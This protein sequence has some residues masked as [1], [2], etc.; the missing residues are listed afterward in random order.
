MCHEETRR[1]EED[2]MPAPKPCPY[3][4]ADEV[5]HVAVR[6]DETGCFFDQYTVA[7]SMPETLRRADRIVYLG[8]PPV[9]RVARIRFVEEKL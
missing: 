4:P 3:A 7:H 5:F 6:G 1:I 9:I 2:V 8:W